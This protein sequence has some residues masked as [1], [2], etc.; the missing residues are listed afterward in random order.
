MKKITLLLFIALFAGCASQI[1]AVSAFNK[2]AIVSLRAAA[3][4]GVDDAAT[5]FCAMSLDTFARH[6]EY[7]GAAAA[8]C[9]KGVPLS[10]LP[11]L[12]PPSVVK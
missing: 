7:Q 6:P 1:Q 8:L 2:S 12:V 11:P 4:V 3:D 5:A 10:A 9:F